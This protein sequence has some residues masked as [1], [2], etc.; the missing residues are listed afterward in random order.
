MLR[1]QCAET[2]AACVIPHPTGLE[3]C[4]LP[5][6][7]EHK[8]SPAFGEAD[9][10]LGQD[11]DVRHVYGANRPGGLAIASS[12]RPPRSA[13][14]NAPAQLS[15]SLLRLLHYLQVDERSLQPAR[16]T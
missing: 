3:G 5:I 6:V 11:V 1:H 12:E 15:W 7:G 14:R 9:H 13:A 8:E 2:E 10:V 16:V 4:V